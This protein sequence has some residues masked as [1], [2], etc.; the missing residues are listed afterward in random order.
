MNDKS[1]SK[2]YIM[3]YKSIKCMSITNLCINEIVY[4]SF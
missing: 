4:T 2:L 3:Y 1:E